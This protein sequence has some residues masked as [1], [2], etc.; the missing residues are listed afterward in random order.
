MGKALSDALEHPAN[1]IPALASDLCSG[2]REPPRAGDVTL[3]PRPGY[4]E[5]NPSFSVSPDG[6]VF[7][8]FG[9]DGKGG[10][11]LTFLVSLGRSKGDAALELIRRAGLEGED[12][13]ARA[14]PAKPNLNPRAQPKAAQAR[15]KA[16]RAQGRFYILSEEESAKLSSWLSPI[17]SGGEAEQE[18]E[19]RGLLPYLG[20]VY[21]ASTL[22]RERRAGK[23]T[24]GVCGAL[25]LEV[26]SP[27][28]A[29]WQGQPWALKIRN[30]GSK[31]EL[32]VKGLERYTYLSS[33]HGSPPLCLSPES[34]SDAVLL[35]EGELSAVAAHVA[36]E[37]VNKAF[38]VQGVAGASAH[39]YSPQLEGKRV[40]IY[41]DGDAGGDGARQNWSTLA[42]E[43]GAASV[44]VLAPLEGERDFCDVLGA[45][46]L[47]ALAQYLTVALERATPFTLEPPL[48]E[49]ARPGHGRLE[50]EVCFDH[51]DTA[52][53][54]FGALGSTND[55]PHLFWNDDGLCRLERGKLGYT[56][57]VLGIKELGSHIQRRFTLF[58]TSWGAGGEEEKQ[59]VNLIDK[60]VSFMLG[61]E[62]EA[63]NHFP[64][65]GGILRTPVYNAAGVLETRE[66]YSKALEMFLDL[67]GRAVPEVPGKPTPEDV[68][69]AR[70]LLLD[71]LLC[72]FPFTD[73]ASRAHAVALG[74]QPLARALIGGPTPLYGIEAPVRGTGKTLLATLMGYIVTGQ[75]VG[76]IAAPTGGGKDSDDE[77]RKTIVAELG[78]SPTVVLFDN[79]SEIDS[80]TLA[81]SITAMTVKARILGYS[82]M[83]TARN[84]FTWVFTA[85][86]PQLSSEIA[87]RTVAIRLES[88]FEE[89]ELREGF[90]HPNLTQWVRENRER[91][92]WALLVLI[93]NW[94][95]LGR[96]LCSK[97]LGSFEDWV[98]VM[99]GILETAEIPGFLDNIKTAQ[100]MTTNDAQQWREFTEA[101]WGEHQDTALTSGVL[102]RLALSG[103]H[104]GHILN[105]KGRDGKERTERAVQT[106][107]GMELKRRAETVGGG[108]I[109]GRFKLTYGGTDSH[110]KAALFQVLELSEVREAPGVTQGPA[111]SRNAQESESET[112]LNP[113]VPLA[114]GPAEVPQRSR[115]PNEGPPT[116]EEDTPQFGSKVPQRSRRG[117]AT[118]PAAFSPVLNGHSRDVRDL[119]GPV[120]TPETTHVSTEGVME[121]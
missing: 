28:A 60:Q 54:L 47:D 121:I 77:W 88:P 14:D 76:V 40:Y 106:A 62:L 97:T 49:A 31:D 74:L 37:S 29:P 6:R 57:K 63:F 44:H 23:R 83:F 114:Q 87:R 100:R 96:P 119:A 94:L 55:P 80:K 25:V 90:K 75:E 95:S 17:T 56:L 48:E 85:N 111:R 39:P 45:D 61:L 59:P 78:N 38:H 13:T 30:P 26:A 99:G 93:Q 24:L 120:A 22:S 110:S 3:D 108:R 115:K 117:P 81:S 64:Y 16:D 52:Q 36:L 98:G 102:L 7:K 104:L 89:P 82:K 92:L 51:Y 53:S 73:D 2:M 42:L 33:G 27:A 32:K 69:A 84:V 1:T 20:T 103:E 91:L 11:A 72:D 65:L 46:G 19:W 107:F 101:W 112:S 66:G 21:R 105:A 12:K 113:A 34:E 8:R 43:R 10:N 41:A 116:L 50:A 9:D 118:G 79:A 70:A 109:I 18:L 35:I 15:Q 5:G 4:E 58:K 71:E 68:G 67:G 86:N